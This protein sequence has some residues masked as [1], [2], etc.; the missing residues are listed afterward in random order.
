MT[1]DE[2]HYVAIAQQ[3]DQALQTAVTKSDT[4]ADEILKA[5]SEFSD[6][7]RLDDARRESAAAGHRDVRGGGDTAL[8]GE[9]IVTENGVI[10]DV[11]APDTVRYGA[12]DFVRRDSGLYAPQPDEMYATNPTARQDG[13]IDTRVPDDTRVPPDSTTTPDT[14]VPDDGQRSPDPARQLTPGPTLLRTDVEPGREPEAT[15]PR[16]RLPD[17][18]NPEKPEQIAQAPRPPGSYPGR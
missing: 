16:P 12:D 6:S 11:A 4:T 15:V 8:Q 1:P 9:G 2:A 18:I 10:Q 3:P 13:A 5:R 17:P 7:V 14:R